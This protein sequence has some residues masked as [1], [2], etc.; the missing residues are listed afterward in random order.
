MEPPDTRPWY[1]RPRNAI[2]VGPLLILICLGLRFGWGGIEGPPFPF[3]GIAY[4][5]GA[6]GIF[7][8]YVGVTDRGRN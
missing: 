4:L 5:A 2:W 3:W 1:V 7:L 6:A 8:T